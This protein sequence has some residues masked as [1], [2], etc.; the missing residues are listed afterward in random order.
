MLPILHF[1]FILEAFCLSQCL[2]YWI[3]NFLW[4][5]PIYFQCFIAS[6][7]PKYPFKYTHMHK[8]PCAFSPG[9]PRWA[10]QW[11]SWENGAPQG[12]KWA[13]CDHVVMWSHPHDPLLWAQASHRP[14][15]SGPGPGPECFRSISGPQIDRRH[16]PS[17]FPGPGLVPVVSPRVRGSFSPW[18]PSFQV[19]LSE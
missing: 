18:L 13:L 15:H 16:V 4:E 11:A 8:G 10:Y 7:K 19:A 9:K 17:Q 3:E 14:S 6:L 1:L 2:T 12:R 5:Y